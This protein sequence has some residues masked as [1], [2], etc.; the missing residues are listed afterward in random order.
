MPGCVEVACHYA[1]SGGSVIVSYCFTK[2]VLDYLI[3]RARNRLGFSIRFD[4]VKERVRVV[5]IVIMGGPVGG[6][7]A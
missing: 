5:K 6:Y 2:D 7:Y 4:G 1:C 3:G